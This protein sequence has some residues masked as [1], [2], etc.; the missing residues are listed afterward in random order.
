MKR[1][2]TW[3]WLAACVFGSGVAVA[4]TAPDPRD[5]DHEALR[6]LM[7]TATEAVNTRKFDLLAPR[8]HAGFTVIAVDSTKLV[9]VDAFR[10]YWNGLFDGPDAPLIAMETRP[11]ADELTFF[12][13]DSVG[14]VYGTSEDTFTFR[15][16]AVF[17]EGEK[18]SMKTR[19]SAAVVKEGDAWKLVNVHFSTNPFDNPMLDAATGAVKRT[20]VLA[21][22]AGLLLGLLLMGLLRRRG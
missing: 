5:G 19:W 17:K 18:R 9:G 20:A 13:G 7:R 10:T 6:A 12:L 16:N 8:L 3:L 14:V 11:V 4:Q 1:I 2:A 22:V 15:K 21:G